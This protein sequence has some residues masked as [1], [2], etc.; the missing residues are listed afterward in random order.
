MYYFEVKDNQVIKYVLELDEE[1][2]KE[3]RVEII[4]KCSY[5][6]HHCHYASKD[7]EVREEFRNVTWIKANVKEF[8]D[9]SVE[10][11]YS[12]DYDFYHFPLLVSLIDDILGYD[13]KAV[14]KIKRLKST[15]NKEEEFLKEQRLLLLS[16]SGNQEED[17]LAFKKLQDKINTYYES[18]ELNK[19][20][21]SEVFYQ[22]QVLSCIHIKK[23]KVLPLDI[24]LEVKNFLSDV[25]ISKDDAIKQ[26]IKK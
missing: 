19:N 10:D 1:K 8:D 9:T 14:E 15:P 17:S 13:I 16:L 23:V 12:I 11:H 7:F 20:Q 2:L 4:E 5:I 21:I 25:S 22:N 18:R 3:L 26:L 6:T 24:V